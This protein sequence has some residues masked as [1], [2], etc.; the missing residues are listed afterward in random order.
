M[1][2]NREEIPV[3]DKTIPRE[4]SHAHYGEAQVAKHLAVYITISRVLK[5]DADKRVLLSTTSPVAGWER[6]ATFHRTKTRGYKLF[7]LRRWLLSA[8]L[9]PN[10]DL[11]IVI[12]EI[13]EL[14]AALEEV[15]IPVHK[16]FTWLH[17]VDN[18]PPGHDFI[19]NSLRS[20]KEP[21]LRAPSSKMRC[22]VDTMF[23]LEEKEEKGLRILR[24]LFSVRRA[25]GEVVAEE[26]IAEN[27]A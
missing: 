22:A 12:G 27:S 19:R 10:K 23:S 11:A 25:V 20:S 8:L 4:R 26:A 24:S 15:G 14:L 7:F 18:L 13:I 17:F 1:R 3:N 2:G 16:E 5:S 9:Q 21:P 6:I